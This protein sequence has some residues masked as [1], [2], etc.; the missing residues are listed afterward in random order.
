MS[1]KQALAYWATGDVRHA[2]TALRIID[3][4]ANTNRQFGLADQNGPL[5]AAWVGQ[6]MG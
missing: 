3:G 6:L 4:W 2:H 1:Y 5:E